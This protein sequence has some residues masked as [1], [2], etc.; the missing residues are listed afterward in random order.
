MQNYHIPL[1][2]YAPGGH[3]APGHIRTLTSQ[4][5]YAPTL[6]GLLNWSYP[7]RFFGHDVR[8]IDPKEAHA[9]I[10]SYQKVGHLENGNF[11][12]LSQ[13]RGATAY[14][15]DLKART[16]IPQKPGDYDLT[17]AISFYE[18]ASYMYKNGLYRELTTEEFARFTT[19][20]Q[21]LLQPGKIATNP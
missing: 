9:L 7:S 19:L 21:K 17:E 10:G 8:K 2:I 18:A 5:D 13:Q 14:H 20:G 16:Q 4:M 6:L 15:Y 1:I 12:V 11:V 3:I